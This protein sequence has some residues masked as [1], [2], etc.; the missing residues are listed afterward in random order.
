MSTKSTR[1]LALLAA[2]LALNL[3]LAG[4]NTLGGAGED[5]EAAGDALED[6]AE[7]AKSY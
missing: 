3:S 4:C 6:E 1:L 2:L 5:I 7:E